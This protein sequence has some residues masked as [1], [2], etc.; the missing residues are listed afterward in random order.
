MPAISRAKGQL[1]ALG[2]SYRFVPV[3][4]AG[5]FHPKVCLR[6]SDA[7]ALISCGSANLSQS[8]WLGRPSGEGESGNREVA[9]AW[10]VDPQTPTVPMLRR[11]IDGLRAL[12]LHAAARAVVERATERNWIEGRAKQKRAGSTACSQGAS[13]R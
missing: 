1:L 9:A 6:L 5:A 7:G 10:R 4:I 8:G 12:P 2:R 13:K 3:H 11:L